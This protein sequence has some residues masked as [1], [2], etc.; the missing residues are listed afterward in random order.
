[1][2]GALENM[3]RLGWIAALVA[4]M[5]AA[6]WTAGLWMEMQRAG[7][8]RAL[9]VDFAVFWAAAKLTL[10]HGPLVPFDLESLNAARSLP[11]G[12]ET[13]TMLWLYPPAWLVLILPFGYL[14]FFWGW[15]IFV[16][17]SLITFGLASR[18]P[19]RGL[20]GAW[21]LLLSSPVVLILLALGQN[22]LIFVSLFILAME[23][24]RRDQPVIAGLFIAAMTL[25]PH[26]GMAIPVALIA[27]GQWRVI[28]WAVIGT[29]VI[30]ATSLVWPGLDY[31]P[32][33]YTGI[34]EGAAEVQASYLP[35][36]MA[37]GYGTGVV[38]GL[39]REGA[40]L[41]QA[42]VSLFAALGLAWLW[43]ERS[44]WD[45]K[46]AGLAFTI[47]LITP[48]AIYYELVFAV[49]GVLYLA[50]AGVLTGRLGAL[51]AIAVWGLPVLGLVLFR[52]PGFAFALPLVGLGLCIAIARARHTPGGERDGSG[53]H[54]ARS[55]GVHHG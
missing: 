1:M 53:T 30:V 43:R 26:L 38:I 16:L 22:S 50:R 31:W 2:T 7:P 49:V 15:L 21:L 48:Y 35:S 25:K 10:A 46:V 6:A 13:A 36:I 51:Y 3:R 52:G 19:C 44:A 5:C 47:I 39:G 24:M 34:T 29:A 54:G 45:L 18:I 9:D 4:A 27:A 42:G 41:L 23:A 28:A 37:T 40:I 11:E 32:A 33:L 17:I 55:E 12:T 20:P 14:P 8:G